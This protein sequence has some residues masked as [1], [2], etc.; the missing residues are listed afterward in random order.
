LSAPDLLTEAS[1][2]VMPGPGAVRADLPAPQLVS[3]PRA[4]GAAG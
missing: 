1:A 4:M 3:G 2:E